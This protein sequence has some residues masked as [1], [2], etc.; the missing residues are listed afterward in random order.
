MQRSFCKHAYK[1]HNKYNY[2]TIQHMSL[3]YN[4][5]GSPQVK[6]IYCFIVF[7]NIASI[8]IFAGKVYVPT[9]AVAGTAWCNYL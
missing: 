6:R 1:N 9:I 4:V 5:H 7:G 3:S 8:M 2:V